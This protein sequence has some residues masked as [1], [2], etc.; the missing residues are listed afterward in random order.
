MKKNQKKNEK[1]GA[2]PLSKKQRKKLEKS[3]A[4]LGE[5]ASRERMPREKKWIIALI[6][7]V[8]VMAIACA[9]FGSI[10]LARVIKDARHDPYASVFEELKLQKY[11]DKKAFDRSFY[12]T[13]HFD[14]TA[15]ETT[16]APMTLADMDAY[17]EKVRVNHRILEK[18]MQKD[19]V[20][21]LGDTVA[22]YVTD[23]FAGDA[24]S[25][26][27]AERAQRLE[28]PSKM[29]ELFG[30]Y[31]NYITLVVGGELFGKDFDDK[32]IASALKPTDTV[33]EVREN[34]KTVEGG[35][36]K[37]AITTD[38]TVCI[39]YYFQ[40]SK[41]SSETPYAKNAEDRYVW[42]SS[43]E[44]DYTKYQERVDL[45]T[46]DARFAEALAENCKAVG[47]SFTFVMEDYNLTGGDKVEDRESDYLVTAQVLFV[48]T[49]E[50]TKDITFTVP[51]GY[52]AES[53]GD[54]YA[55]NGKTATLRVH[56]L[57]MDDYRLPDFNRAFITETL[58]M[59]ISAA[60]D[61]GAINEFKE[62]ELERLNKE[63]AENKLL[64]WYDTA[65]STLAAKAKQY[66]YFL[67]TATSADK[68]AAAV[69]AQITR[70]L[71]EN[72]LVS[73]GTVPTTAELDEYAASLAK[74]KEIDATSAEEYIAAL[75]QAQGD[76]IKSTELVTYAV[77]KAERMKITDEALDEAYEEYMTKLVGS[78]R[79]PETNNKEYFVEL[80][81][82]EML[83]SWV[84][85]DLVYKMV[86]EYLVSANVHTPK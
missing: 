74:M 44:A 21:G 25:D 33:R 57:Y 42:S 9:S 30:T 23:V 67:E 1:R 32:L 7:A 53:D 46:L 22:L 10:L 64:A 2:Q 81:G 17:I 65:I 4:V 5:T 41:R 79:D 31:T 59:E 8:C 37:V 35:D 28:I 14:F 66:G 68:I 86:G 6:A 62:K 71:L 11:L 45:S 72:F 77:F 26:A 52:F 48:I 38:E 40:K 58:K 75:C 12:A 83:K 19:R 16:Y 51:A 84:R 63:L 24:P 3:G 70:T 18:E 78:M 54:F 60:D 80:Y 50:T 69:E 56:V 39:T 76:Q 61:T 55:L 20:I 85:R 36:K 34:N 49:E 29:E 73:R 47:E 27:T 43:A 13:Q 82:E 15:H